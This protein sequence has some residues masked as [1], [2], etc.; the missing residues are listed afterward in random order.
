MICGIMTELRGKFGKNSMN[1][2]F[3]KNKKVFI[4]G[5][6]G[7][8]G[9]WLSIV[10]KSLGSDIYGFSLKPDTNPSLFHEAKINKFTKSFFGDI[11]D[12]TFLSKSLNEV[13]PEIV[14]HL[15]AQPLV[16][17]SYLDPINTYKTNVIGTVNILEGIRQTK[18]VK[19]FVNI[20]TDKCYE[21]KEWVWGYRENDPLGGY[22]PYS[23]SKACSE[24]VTSSYTQSFFDDNSS[25]GIATARAGNV[26][27]GGDWS[28]DRLVPDV[29]KSF[30]KNE[31]VKIRNPK[32][33]RPWQHV[34][35][36]IYGY[37]L[38]A[39]NL[40]HEKKEYSGS[41]NFGPFSEGERDVEYV[42][43][44]LCKH[45]DQRSWHID[46]SNENPHEANFLKLDISKSISKLNWKPKYKI[47]E[48]ILKTA[49]WYKN[50]NNKNNALDLCMQEVND[51]FKGDI[52]EQI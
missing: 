14:F 7:F 31:I 1:L 52:N 49:N 28:K 25:P 8:K 26:I 41:Y 40:W 35:E 4:T 24:L 39:Q 12:L 27:G 6:T 47:E 33:T 20:T 30:G 29:I 19:A 10:L 3:W 45:F 51:F 23:S 42:V 50:W 18:S 44:Q 15:A 48:S 2:G 32:S 38:L 34:L 11:N 13:E 21:N 16:R 17:D 43:Q 36:P 5:H 9:S 46:E 37:I 22:D